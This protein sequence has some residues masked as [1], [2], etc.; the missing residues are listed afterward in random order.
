MKS[1]VELD[2]MFDEIMTDQYQKFIVFRFNPAKELFR[3][4]LDKPFRIL[5]IRQGKRR[6]LHRDCTT[7]FGKMLRTFV[8]EEVVGLFIPI[9]GIDVHESAEFCIPPMLKN[10]RKQILAFSASHNF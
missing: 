5:L 4:G 9:M 3:K 1:T 2:L 8:I 6:Q 10:S 7:S